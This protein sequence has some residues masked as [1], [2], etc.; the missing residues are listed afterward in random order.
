MYLVRIPFIYY[1]STFLGFLSNLHELI[2]T[3]RLINF[4]KNFPPTCLFR[5]TDLLILSNCF[6]P[7]GLLFWGIFQ[8]TY[9][10]LPPYRFINFDEF[11]PHNYLHVWPAPADQDIFLPLSNALSKIILVQ[12]KS[13]WTGP[14]MQLILVGSKLFWTSPNHKS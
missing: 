11:F 14:I 2:W 10:F 9:M 8:H 12:Y 7:T 3:Y 1:V 5:P 4:E 13:F 6:H